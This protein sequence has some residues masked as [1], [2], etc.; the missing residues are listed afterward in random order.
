M[1]EILTGSIVLVALI[2]SGVLGM[3]SRRPRHFSATRSLSIAAPRDLIHA[4]IDNLQRMNTWNPYVL[5]DTGG[6]VHY[7][8]PEKGP[9]AMF[10]F[11]GSKSGSGSLRILAS[12]PSRIAMRLQMTKPMAADNRVEFT[13]SPVGNATLVTWA[14]SGS[15]SF[16]AR[17]MSVFIDCDKMI[18]RDFDEGLHNLKTIAE[19]S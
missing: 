1:M 3:A 11:G 12:E 17:V 2:F 14:M 5:R 18:G 13:L 9:G 19:Q 7:S 4:L 16:P 10:E 8:G 6:Q 15:Q